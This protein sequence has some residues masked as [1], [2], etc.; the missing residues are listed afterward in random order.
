[1]RRN[2]QRFFGV[3]SSQRI[4]C[5]DLTP[6]PPART[7]TPSQ[8]L[9]AMTLRNSELSQAVVAKLRNSTV[10]AS[11]PDYTFLVDERYAIRKGIGY[12][13]T[14]MGRFK[15]DEFARER[16]RELEIPLLRIVR[17]MTPRGSFQRRWHTESWTQ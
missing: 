4:D 13:L 15:A 1:M 11:G 5:Q 17:A 6:A 9:A 2:H 14:P 16:A 10:R 7:F 12:E 3:L 8:Q